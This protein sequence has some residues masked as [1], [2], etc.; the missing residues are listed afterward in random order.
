VGPGFL[1]AISGALS[2]VRINRGRIMRCPL[3]LSSPH[4][5]N[6]RI[7]DF[8][9]VPDGKPTITNAQ[10]ASATSIRLSWRP[11]PRN[12]LHG[13]FLGYRLA[14]RPRD[15]GPTSIQEIYIRDPHVEVRH[16]I[17]RNYSEFQCSNLILQTFIIQ[18]LLTFTQYLVSLQVFNPEGLGPPTTVAV[19]TDEGG[20]VTVYSFHS[21]TF[22][23]NFQFESNMT[24]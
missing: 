13:E 3:Y 2:L 21:V 22:L 11:P 16:S 9:S 12:T 23:A 10:N 19:I 14:F 7:N 20:Q 4:T 24:S 17:Y 15:R 5:I 1:F 18:N 8:L 6:R